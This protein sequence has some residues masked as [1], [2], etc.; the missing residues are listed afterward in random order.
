[1]TIYMQAMESN[2]RFMQSDKTSVHLQDLGY[3]GWRCNLQL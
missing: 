3:F 2:K 1:M